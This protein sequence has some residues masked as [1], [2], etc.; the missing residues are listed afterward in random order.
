VSSQTL[1]ELRPS[2]NV[3]LRLCLGR[4][5]ARPSKVVT[6][7]VRSTPPEMTNLPTLQPTRP[8]L[9]S[10]QRNAIS[11]RN[12]RSSAIAYSRSAVARPGLSADFIQLY[13]ADDFQYLTHCNR[14]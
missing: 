3:P 8:K 13:A 9:D 10:R 12:F 5:S 4:D 7:V 14:G 6:I 11:D 2:S 1:N